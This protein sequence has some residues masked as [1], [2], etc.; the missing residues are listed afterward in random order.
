MKRILLMAVALLLVMA[1]CLPM[2]TFVSCARK[3]VI[4]IYTSSEDYRV[5]YYQKR[6]NEEFPEYRI[7][8]EYKTT[9][10]HAA[11]LKAAG[12]KTE[13]DIS[14]EMEYTLAAELVELGVYA[15]LADYADFSVY[16]DGAVESTYYL[17]AFRSGGAVVL[18]MDVIREKGL[19]V[20][21]SYEDLLDPQYKNL[22]SMPNPK[23]SGTGYIYLLNLVNS[24]G[25]DEA[26]SYFDR[27]EDNILT[28]TSS[29]S[30]P[31]NALVNKE[32]AVG[33]G[34][35][36]L[37]V[38]KMNEG[39]NLKTV[40]FEEG[41]PYTMYGMGVI[42]GKETDEDVMR[43]FKFLEEVLNKE[44]CERYYPEKIY[45]NSDFEIEN[46]PRDIVY[47]DMSNNTPA[48]KRELLD[49]WRY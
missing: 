24:M 16:V 45:K 8:L 1:F 15:D 42:A 41:S 26:F 37:A 28:F 17:P 9:G 6:L 5:E 46:Y 32:V 33:L 21:T 14:Y 18:N 22:I 49:K 40:Y 34:L 39:A 38:T 47:G 3:K 31:V 12:S 23:S 7:I 43:V 48:R 35:T 4:V 29:G 30:G 10:D 44:N 19:D 25:E 13:C 20:P 2:F 11:S 27:L 36:A